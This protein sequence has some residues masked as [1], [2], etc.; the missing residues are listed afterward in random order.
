MEGNTLMKKL[1]IDY[2]KKYEDKNINKWLDRNRIVFHAVTSDENI[3]IIRSAHDNIH[4]DMDVD[5]EQFDM[6]DLIDAMQICIRIAL[7]DDVLRAR[8]DAVKLLLGEE[9]KHYLYSK[10]DY[11][12]MGNKK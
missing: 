11:I 9:I 6:L 4:I 1:T 10:D 7:D 8:S 2:D 12:R 5:L 3:K